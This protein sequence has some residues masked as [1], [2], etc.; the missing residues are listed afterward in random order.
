MHQPNHEFFSTISSMNSFS[1]SSRL[2]PHCPGGA[3]LWSGGGTKKHGVWSTVLPTPSLNRVGRFF[4][5]G[6][7]RLETTDVKLCHTPEWGNHFNLDFE[8]KCVGWKIFRKKD[9][10]QFFQTLLCF[11]CCYSFQTLP[12]FHRSSHSSLSLLRLQP[13][14]TVSSTASPPSSMLRHPDSV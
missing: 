8:D 12:F 5:A 6:G 3:S 9:C 2:N 14:V 13:C 11:Y 7:I 1:R 10:W 4:Q